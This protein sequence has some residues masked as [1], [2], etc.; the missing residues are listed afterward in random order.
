MLATGFCRFSCP[1][2]QG[3]KIKKI[4]IK[5]LPVFRFLGIQ[6]DNEVKKLQGLKNYQM[7]SRRKIMLS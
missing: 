3:H 6:W 4:T 2:K 5:G 7:D 1:C